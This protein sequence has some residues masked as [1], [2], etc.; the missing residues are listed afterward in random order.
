MT[1]CKLKPARGWARICGGE[2]ERYVYP[3]K[4]DAIGYYS[5]TQAPVV[6]AVLLPEADYH[7]L[8][9]EARKTRRKA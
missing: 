6:R 9:R 4:G 8:V 5:C 2:L 1:R 7:R 3:N